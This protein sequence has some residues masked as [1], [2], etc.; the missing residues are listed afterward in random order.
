VNPVYFAPIQA[1]SIIQFQDRAF[2]SGREVG[3]NNVLGEDDVMFN[4]MDGHVVN[5]LVKAGLFQALSGFFHQPE[6]CFDPGAERFQFLIDGVVRWRR[7]KYSIS[8]G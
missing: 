2:L 5:A 8:A 3:E 1:F 6:G 7:A 4:G